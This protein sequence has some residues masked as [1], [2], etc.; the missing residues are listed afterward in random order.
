MIKI[1]VS[2]QLLYHR[3]KT[4]VIRVYPIST[5]VKGVGNSQGSFQT[6][7]GKHRVFAKIGEGLPKGAV[8]VARVPVDVFS[9]AIK[10]QR[11]DWILSRILWLEGVQAGVNKFGSV[12]SLERYIYIHG[13]D[14]EDLIGEPASHGC[15]R[16]LNQ[17]V[18]DL[19]EDVS[20]GELVMIKP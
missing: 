13:T 16:M 19:F 6:P 8:F 1:V 11:K 10:Y 15:I 14:E 3:K 2:E 7:L 4:G 9:E 17:D 18:I 5:A 12:D 20:C